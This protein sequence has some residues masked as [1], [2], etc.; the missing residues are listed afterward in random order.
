MI[1]YGQNFKENEIKH[2]QKRELIFCRL[3]AHPYVRDMTLSH[4][5]GGN[6][7]NFKGDHLQTSQ[8]T[9]RKYISILVSNN[10]YLKEKSVT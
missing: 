5:Q 10:L 3:L 7:F 6:H 4:K 8:I 1:C 9:Y 2:D